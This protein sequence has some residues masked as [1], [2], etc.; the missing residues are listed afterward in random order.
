M[1]SDTTTYNQT[2]M[3]SAA[4]AYSRIELAAF[5]KSARLS[6]IRPVYR[7]RTKPK[8]RPAI[9]TIQAAF[10][11]V[12]AIWN[13]QRIDLSE[14]IVAVYLNASYQAIGWVVVASGGISSCVFDKRIVLA[15][16]LQ[17]A[18][19]AIILA[20]NHPSG[21][22]QPSADDKIITKSLNDGCERL[23]IK[24]LDHIILT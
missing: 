15:I 17:T 23:G 11:Y 8:Q 4:P 10:N 13:E 1:T 19:T 9:H 24:L 14:D 22:L 3:K 7:S 12:R 21:N 2:P 6:E 18:S 16:A 5:R 20:H